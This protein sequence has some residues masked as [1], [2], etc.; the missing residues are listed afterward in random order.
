M[1]KNLN[2]TSV[3]TTDVPVENHTQNV[4]RVLEILLTANADQLERLLEILEE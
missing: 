3:P 2:T 1:P 4:N